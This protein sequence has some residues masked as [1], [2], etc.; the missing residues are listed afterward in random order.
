MRNTDLTNKPK[1]K[2]FSDDTSIPSSSKS[3]SVSP[4]KAPRS[5][6]AESANNKYSFAGNYGFGVRV[7][8][9]TPPSSSAVDCSEWYYTL[10]MA[11]YRSFVLHWIILL[12]S[13]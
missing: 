11:T 6:I 8:K 5:N 1:K 3:S 7:G 4:R 10:V 12:H 2:R 9:P 13:L